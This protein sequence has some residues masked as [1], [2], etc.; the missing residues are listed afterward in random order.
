MSEPVTITVQAE[1]VGTEPDLQARMFIR[2]LIKNNL[3][4]V[5]RDEIIELLHNE[6]DRLAK[7]TMEE[8]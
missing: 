7:A 3:Q 8:L 4:D 2:N 6:A 1:Y 5:P